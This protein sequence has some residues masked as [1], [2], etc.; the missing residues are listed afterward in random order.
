M[1]SGCR[2]RSAKKQ[3]PRPRCLRRTPHAEPLCAILPKL[4]MCKES[5]G[6]GRSKAF[7]MFCCKAFQMSYQAP[8]TCAHVA[9]AAT[10]MHN[11]QCHP[12]LL[13][14]ADTFTPGSQWMPGWD[15]RCRKRRGR[16]DS[17]LQ[18]HVPDAHIVLDAHASFFHTQYT[19]KMTYNNASDFPA[20]RLISKRSFVFVSLSMPR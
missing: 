19:Y 7:W 17:E 6:I 4:P 8:T 14:A 12:E 1:R 15:R 13:V 2:Q 9:H 10:L 16:T 20:G 5:Q 18:Q 3:T 11:C